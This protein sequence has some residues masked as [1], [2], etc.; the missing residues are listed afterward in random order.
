MFIFVQYIWNY[1]I[2]VTKF[3]ECNLLLQVV[4]ESGLFTPEDISYVQDAGS[5][6][7][8]F[9]FT[10]VWCALVFSFSIALSSYS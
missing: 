4:S 5:K 8:S 6:A 2:S 10:S 3:L 9:L 7:V 1:I